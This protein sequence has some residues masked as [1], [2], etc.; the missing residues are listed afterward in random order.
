MKKRLYVSMALIT[1]SLHY[2]VL[3]PKD[4]EVS[5]SINF[6]IPDS[7][8]QLALTLAEDERFLKAQRMPKPMF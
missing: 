7:S 8:G 3:L 2:I 1:L 4:M 6:D 5:N